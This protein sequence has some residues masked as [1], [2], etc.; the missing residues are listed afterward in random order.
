[1]PFVQ[2]MRCLKFEQWPEPRNATPT[3][4]RTILLISGLSS[5]CNSARVFSMTEGWHLIF[6]P[7]A[8]TAI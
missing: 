8:R 5:E 3:A 7:D 6:A 2:I 1:M 4:G